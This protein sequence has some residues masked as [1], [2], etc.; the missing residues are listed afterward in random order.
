MSGFSSLIVV[1]VV[2]VVGSVFIGLGPLGC[3]PL[4]ANALGGIPLG[5]KGLGLS[6]LGLIPLGTGPLGPPLGAPLGPPVGEPNLILGEPLPAPISIKD[7]IVTGLGGL[8]PG[9]LPSKPGRWLGGPGPFH[10]GAAMFNQLQ[11]STKSNSTANFLAPIFL[12]TMLSVNSAIFVYDF[13]C[14]KNTGNN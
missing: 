9:P 4:G 8:G 13:S 5:P 11:I 12:K 14:T 2:G 6:F 7:P 1:T 3:G 10:D